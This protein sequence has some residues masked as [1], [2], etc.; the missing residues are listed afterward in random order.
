MR[1]FFESDF[2]WRREVTL[3]M[4]CAAPFASPKTPLV[5]LMIAAFCACASVAH[6]ADAPIPSQPTAQYEEAI[7]K[8]DALFEEGNYFDAV[9]MYER[10]SRIVYNNKLQTDSASLDARL[11]KVRCGAVR[12]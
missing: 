9:L 4:S 3:K 8:G 2:E 5:A 7:R 12:A 11:V 10:A 6:A 1:V